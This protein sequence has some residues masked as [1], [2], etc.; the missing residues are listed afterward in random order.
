[1]FGCKKK[2]IYPVDS[3]SGVWTVFQV[4]PNIEGAA[5]CPN[6]IKQ[7][8]KDLTS[9]A[10]HSECDI[11]DIKSLLLFLFMDDLNVNVFSKFIIT[12]HMILIYDKNNNLVEKDEVRKILKMNENEY[13][14]LF[15]EE[16]YAKAY[17]D[18]G[19]L[20]IHSSLADFYLR[21]AE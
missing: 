6:E 17:V 21:R 19:T 4:S 10:N 16:N 18:N 20:T 11:L 2:E 14:I 8:K 13:K 9:S 15:D 5:K 3:I 12:P 1:M 7:E